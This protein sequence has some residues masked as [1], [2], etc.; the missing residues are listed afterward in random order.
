MDDRRL[1]ILI[2]QLL[3]AGVLLAA[4]IVLAGGVLYLARHGADR[5][6][7]HSFVAGGTDTRTL[8]GIVQ[9]AARGDG[10]GW[11]LIGLVL[12]VLTPIARVAVAAVGF[13]L[14]RDRLYTVVSLIHAT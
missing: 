14:E 11:I 10:E 4:A 2:G 6:N 3:R 5:A 7:Y 12:L 9:S 13:F 1:E 8:R